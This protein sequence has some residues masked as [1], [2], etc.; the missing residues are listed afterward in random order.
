MKGRS[1]G[2]TCLAVY[3]IL[4]GLVLI[5][6]LAFEGLWIIEGALALIA[7]IALLVGR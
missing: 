6:H 5:L 3:L 7:G 2:M 1:I 4:V